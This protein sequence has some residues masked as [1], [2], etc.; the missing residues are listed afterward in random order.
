MLAFAWLKRH[1]HWAGLVLS[2]ALIG[3]IAFVAP[4]RV[5]VMELEREAAVAANRLRAQIVKEPGYLLD[6]L[7]QPRLRPQLSTVFEHSGYGHRV[8]RYELYD[9]ANRLIFTSGKAG[10]A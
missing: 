1:G 3:A 6:A 9:E 10:L 2:S 5:S 8:L 7:S 4:S